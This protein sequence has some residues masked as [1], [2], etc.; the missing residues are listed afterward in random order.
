MVFL[1][2]SANCS[3]WESQDSNLPV[4]CW[5]SW[6]VPE[7]LI[8]AHSYEFIHNFNTCIHIYSYFFLKNEHREMT[9]VLEYPQHMFWLRNKKSFLCYA[10]KVLYPERCYIYLPLEFKKR[11]RH[12]FFSERWHYFLISQQKFDWRISISDTSKDFLQNMFSLR[13]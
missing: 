3:R 13:K 2:R 1:G 11:H 10:L 9:W 8:T 6:R 5:S 12:L 7:Q 4:L